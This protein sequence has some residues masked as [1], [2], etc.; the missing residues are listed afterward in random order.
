M[1][2]LRVRPPASG[3]LVVPRL[4]SCATVA[5]SGIERTIAKAQGGGGNAPS[6]VGR[7][8]AQDTADMKAMEIAPARTKPVLRAEYKLQKKPHKH[9][10]NS[11]RVGA[12]AGVSPYG[13]FDEDGAGLE[14]YAQ[15]GRKGG[16]IR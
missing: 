14:T 1:Q 4:T 12:K 16:I 7:I 6:G 9:G 15:V 10:D 8:S 13:G 11:S 3:S 5:D 2:L